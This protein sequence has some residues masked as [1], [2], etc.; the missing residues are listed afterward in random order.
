[1]PTFRMRAGTAALA[2]TAVV[3][4]TAGLTTIP[5]S[6]PSAPAADGADG[7]SGGQRAA[8]GHWIT[9]ITGDQVAVDGKGQ[10]TGVR[11]AQGREDVPYTVRST[12]GHTY[13]VPLDAAALIRQGTVDQR[14]FDVTLQNRPEYRRQQRAGIK[15]IVGYRG[16]AAGAKADLRAA[17]GTKVGRA[18]PRLGAEAVTTQKS[19]AGEV[20]SALTEGDR[21]APGVRRVWLDGVR[22]A[23]LDKSVPQIGAP[24]AWS[25]GYDGTGVR[26]AVLDTGVDATH[27]DLADQ[28]VA[29]QN[30]SA[31]PDDLDHFGHGTHVASIAAG[32]GAKSGGTFKGVAPGAKIL[33]GKVLDD[34]GYGDDTG[35]LAGFEWAVA[36]GADIVNLSLSGGDTPELDPLEEAVNRISAEKGILFAASAGNEGELGPRTVGSPGSADA[37]LTV[38]AVDD[39]DRLADFSSR[40][41]RVGD[42]AVKP[43]VTAPG[44]DITAAAAP[45]SYIE[46]RVG[47]DPEGYLTISGTSM[48][49][50]HAAGAAALLA[51]QHPDWTGAQLKAALVGSAEPGS[52]YTPFE[53]G[54]GRIAVD[55]ALGQSVLAESGPVSFGKQLWPHQDDEPV[56]R[57]IT[58]RN[59]GT[60]DVTLDLAATGTGPD[61]EPAPAG[62]F[63]MGRAQV[64]VPAGGTAEVPVTADTR[65]GGTLDGM[66]ALTVTATGGGQS[67]RTAGGVER[68]VESY[69]LTVRHLDRAGL[70][71]GD[72]ETSLIDST[73]QF[74]DLFGMSFLY[75]P[76]GVVKL[77]VPAGRYSL[78]TDIF[79]RTGSELKSFD[80]VGQPTLV[81]D[82]DRTV[83][84]DART[85]EP[86]VV[87]V[88][89]SGARP[90]DAEYTINHSFEN[91]G[92]TISYGLPSFRGVR[93]AHRGA[94]AAEGELHQLLA[95]TFQRGS[96]LYKVAYGSDRTRVFT[97]YTKNVPWSELAEHRLTLGSSVAG[98]T[99]SLFLFPWTM[100]GGG[101][102]AAI[103]RDLPFTG[104]LYVNGSTRTSWQM[105]FIQGG[106]EAD[107]FVPDRSYAGG[108]TYDTT[109]NVG[110]F[111]P[112]LSPETDLSRDEDTL[113]MALP[114]FNDGQG[115]SG[116]SEYDSARTVLYRDGAELEVIEDLPY[117]T[118]T[119]PPEQADYKLTTTVTR[120][121]GTASVT[122]KVTATWTFASARATEQLPA[123]FVRFT[124]QL[125]ADSTAKAG[126]DLS[127]PVQIQGSAA[128][129]NLRSL[130]VA[131]SFDGGATWQAL[132][133][134][135]GE[136][137]VHNPAPGK[138]VSLRA[139]AVDKQGNTFAVTLYDA[140]RTR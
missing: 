12:K 138:T 89:D 126:A 88:P 14:L 57:A 62:M 47:Q 114:L 6:A 123:S 100:G 118:F 19:G 8:G 132:P 122:T 35:I 44:V 99:G 97:G 79:V 117:G 23:S 93:M 78:E 11:R 108:K 7:A 85:T 38:G 51:Q 16:A 130:S 115:H 22:R 103:V 2:A 31:S 120:P 135:D 66:Y 95:A 30:F 77:R 28:V 25:A 32:T 139:K 67:V 131:A 68:E 104:L 92:W 96:N 54:T 101:G 75:D 71:T 45:G 41:P 53:Q 84:L 52:G 46:Q 125:A 59:L 36:Q 49:A 42:S 69:D 136:V 129:G 37:A 134:A 124:P 110:V 26:I 140:Y 86:V 29:A 119:L 82:R 80:F 48:A 91:I 3:A 15:L 55:R 90:L 109:L 112:A 27:P 4:L 107:Y 63:T 94:P 87:T 9:L 65:Q 127:V 5:R 33:A 40:G 56:T 18:F 50:P 70:L 13:V 121:A 105:E 1:M 43:D 34:D 17:D 83:T 76:S 133:V 137:Q 20:W 102:S 74:G 21:A 72:Y 60:A 64:T 24:A 39:E 73:G 10:V 116:Y 111:G 98:K 58:Y 61:G 81:M 106:F 113:Y 128:D